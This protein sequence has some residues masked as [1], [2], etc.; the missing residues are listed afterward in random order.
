M[1]KNIC[2]LM[3]R[4]LIELQ[5]SGFLNPSL[6]RET[7]QLSRIEK[8]SFF[9]PSWRVCMCASFGEDMSS[10]PW[11]VTCVVQES[12]SLMSCT[13][14]LTA[15]CRPYVKAIRSLTSVHEHCKMIAQSKA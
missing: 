7:W 10:I 6:G 8:L 9:L 11:S 5:Q 13:R 4:F 12:F 15:W 3:E 2:F 1:Q 14:T